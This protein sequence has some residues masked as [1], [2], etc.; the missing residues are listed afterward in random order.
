ME[1]HETLLPEPI[2]SVFISRVSNQKIPKQKPT[3]RVLNRGHAIFPHGPGEFLVQGWLWV[4]VR[5]VSLHCRCCSGS[6][7]PGIP[8][9]LGIIPRPNQQVKAK[10][11][12]NTV[13]PSSVKL[14]LEDD[15]ALSRRTQK[16]CC[17]VLCNLVQGG[18]KSVGVF[19]RLHSLKKQTKQWRPFFSVKVWGF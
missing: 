14:P 19:N 7:L 4:T 9:G 18:T 5:K 15:S 6:I 2:A 1:K 10:A 16:D 11:R 12:P 13:P 17:A 3:S 8:P